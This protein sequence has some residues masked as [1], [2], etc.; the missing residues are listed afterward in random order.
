IYTLTPLPAFGVSYLLGQLAVRVRDLGGLALGVLGAALIVLP[1]ALAG[2]EGGGGP[3]AFGDLL[4]VGAMVTF[5]LWGVFA[6]SLLRR[7]G[8]V[9]TTGWTML[10]GAL[11]LAPAAL[12]DLLA[13]DWGHLPPFA[14]AGLLYAG[15][16]TGT[17]G[18][19]L[20]YAAIRRIG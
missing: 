15:V 10:V 17:L 1:P 14:Y 12:P 8:A 7:Y 9:W 3:T 6:A 5:G 13:T 4:M 19:L 2:A 20:W 11:G 18:S 16:V